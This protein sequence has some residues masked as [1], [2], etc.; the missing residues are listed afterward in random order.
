MLPVPLVVIRATRSSREA[1]PEPVAAPSQFPPREPNEGTG[2][3]AA[4]PLDATPLTGSE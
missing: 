2:I 4:L 1:V 3:A